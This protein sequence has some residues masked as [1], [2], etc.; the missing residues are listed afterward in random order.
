LD[1]LLSDPDR[2]LLL[3]DSIVALHFAVVAFALGGAI[4]ILIGGLRGWE[5]VRGLVFRFVHLAVV[6]AVALQQDLCFLTDWEIDLRARAGRGIEEASFVGRILHE[7]LFV[8]VDLVTLQRCYMAFGVLVLLG[9]VAVRPR[10]RAA[11]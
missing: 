1:W 5:W 6:A 7:W 4:A 10:R 8:K 11:R 9:L 3:A 2:C